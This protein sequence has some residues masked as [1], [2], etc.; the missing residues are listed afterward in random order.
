MK[1][2]DK[3]VALEKALLRRIERRK[4]IA[5][6]PLEI[7]RAILDDIEDAT[8]PG[9]RG[10]RIFPYTHITVSVG[11][12][13]PHQRATAEA[14]FTEPPSIED[15]VRERLRDR[16]CHVAG[17]L[18]VTVKFVDATDEA[19]AEREYRIDYRRRAARRGHTEAVASPAHAADPRTLH[20]TVL[21]GSAA[22]RR[23][24]FKAERI[25]LGRLADV[26]DRHQ[27]V[28]RQNQVVFLD[29]GDDISQS[30]SRAHAHVRFDPT[31]GE[32][33][34]HDDGSTYGTRIVRDGRTIDVPRDTAR[35]IKLRDGDEILLGRA[36]VRVELR[37]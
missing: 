18:A 24:T 31:S 7:Y 32:V 15:R 29:Q 4:D 30:V 25:N 17:P 9:G 3:A 12:S 2:L 33:R 26:L 20:M 37:E 19:W 27:H 5:R 35:G 34:L 21:A 28:V 11:T 1:I 36:R 13:G 6:H 14:V 23:Y 10:K 16:G 22:R 8:E